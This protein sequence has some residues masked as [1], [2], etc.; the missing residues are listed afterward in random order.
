[1]KQ[2]FNIHKQ[3]T[4][5]G[6]L[7]L[8][9][10]L[11][12]AQ[13]TGPSPVD[14]NSTHTYEYS[15]GF[16]HNNRQWTVTGG[17]IV[18][19][20][21]TK[22]PTTY[23]VSVL[24]GSGSSGEVV[25]RSN[26]IVKGTKFVTINPVVTITN[27]LS[28][29]NY[30]HTII[31]QLETTDTSVL[32]KE[33]TIETVTYVDGLGRLKQ[34][35]A[36]RAGA[37][38]EDIITPID[39]DNFG[40]SEMDY[41]PY[42][43]SS[44][45]GAYKTDALT[46][47][48]TFYKANFGDDFTGIAEANINPYSQKE[49]EDSPL[50]RVLKQAAPGESWKLGNGHE[51][52]FVYDG[53][54]ANDVRVF[55]VTTSFANN[56]YTPSLVSNGYYAAN[57][58]YMTTTK[59]EDHGPTSGDDHTIQEYKD[60][61]GRVVLKRTHNSG[62]HD[63]YY[64]YDDFGNLTYVIPP[65]VDTSN[66]VSQTELDNLCY[67]YV[68]DQKN[69]LVEKKIPGKGWEY[70]VYNTADQPILTQDDNQRDPSFT[71]K[72][73]FT[74]YDEH[75]RVAYTGE[76]ERNISRTSLQ[77]EVDGYTDTTVSKTSTS[78][79]IDETTIYYDN[80]AYPT[81][82]IS[83]LFMINY[84]DNYTF[85]KVLGSSETSY[86]VT[87]ITDIKGLAAGSKVRVLGTNDWITT[88]TYYN[89][90]SQPIYVYAH[91]AYFNTTDK[92][93]S[94]LNFTGVVLETTTTHARTGF[95]TITTVDAYEYDHMNRLLEHQQTIGTHTEVIVSNTYDELG[96][97]EQKDVGG[98]TSQ[99]GLQN[100]DYTYNVRGWLKQINDPTSLGTD[101]F[102]FKINY[103][104]VDHNGTALFNGNIAET[105]WKTANTDNSLKWYTYEYDA[106]NRITEATSVDPLKL[107][108]DFVGYDKNG[109]ITSL[110]RK[111]H[112]VAQPVLGNTNDYDDMDLLVYTY[113]ATSNRLK[114][115]KDT[116][117]VNFGFIDGVDQTTEYTY[118]D[119]GNMITDANKGITSI[120]YNHLNLPLTVTLSGGNITYIYDATGVKLKK[121]VSTGGTTE[122]AGNYVYVGSSL[123]FFN[124][125]EGFVEPDGSGGYDYVYQYKDHL[126][127]IRLSYKD[128]SLTSTPNL[129]IQEEHNYYPFGLTHQGYNNTP[130][131]THPYRFNGKEINEELDLDWYDF[132]A[133]NYDAALGR[134]MNLDPLAEQMRR[135]SP[136]NYAFNNPLVFT[137]PDGMA[138]YTDLYDLNG[139]K[140]AS[141]GVDNGEKKIV[142][143]NDTVKKVK[144]QSESE[145]KSDLESGS[146]GTDVVDVPSNEVM[147]AIASAYE[148]SESDG[149]ER[150]FMMG[151]DGSVSSTEI[152]TEG[153]VGTNRT[154][155][156]MQDAGKTIA[157]D[158]HTHPPGEITINDD[159]TYTVEGGHTPSPK[160]VRGQTSRENSG[161]YSGPSIVAGTKVNVT[162]KT[163][164]IGGKTTVSTTKTKVLTYYDGS[165]NTTTV[166]YKKFSKAVKKIN[167]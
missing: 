17:T 154:I 147:G 144:K 54:S 141:D 55:T 128:I 32:L 124:Q 18:S 56:T 139:K 85:D 43:V 23:K 165:G 73:L 158:V 166:N 117:E 142:I 24:W 148:G 5:L 119:N 76:M 143:N 49:F 13:V 3:Y 121:T 21:Y 118:D 130:V 74:K 109:N 81:S 48:K 94:D 92:V 68:Y 46:S 82:Y 27:N 14:A 62:D 15:D 156:E 146:Y 71:D 126:G 42:P 120:T 100:V 19:E 104:T 11:S 37:G 91:N 133:R 115:V 40:R 33:N 105:E 162:R 157:G 70:I 47:N 77:S 83:D 4:L 16:Q 41:L 99:G 95:T 72:W 63:T 10:Q 106:L 93:K 161:L 64:V 145:V 98:T 164:Q 65:L 67:Q 35:N 108:L 111:G 140:I 80:S 110:N 114:K 57:T 79:T 90:K 78:T 159:G 9:A 96:Q 136:F 87:P 2:F 25:F 125:P 50:S 31:P 39:Y 88:V 163:S 151:T 84:Y 102:G 132:G 86:G 116:G 38:N 123:K 59:D 7:L 20:W 112:K 127:N 135:H 28:D 26:G 30:I 69:R 122:Y 51:I 134:W 66:G 6:I 131:T 12:L 44:N 36:I 53:N 75:G 152:G 22:S 61:Q 8:I 107:S 34:N 1:M 153:E 89:D 58:L 137:D 101:L 113:E 149:N 97:L 138:P 60:K 129:Q 29:E 160:D 167:D 150:G 155:N 103:N 52:E 45:N